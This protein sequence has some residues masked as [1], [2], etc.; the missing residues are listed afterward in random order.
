MC[1]MQ[2]NL[3]SVVHYDCNFGKWLQRNSQFSVTEILATTTDYRLPTAYCLLPT[4]KWFSSS[5]S[6]AYAWHVII[7]LWH[8]IRRW[9]E[10]LATARCVLREQSSHNQLPLRSEPP[11]PSNNQRPPYPL[12]PPRRSLLPL[13][14]V[15]W[16][17][18]LCSC[19]CSCY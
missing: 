15:K 3:E 8:T 19:C 10:M 2:H 16:L 5:T 14:P 17:C 11:N 4:A 1:C 7:I 6:C 13:V 9:A 18:E 12:P